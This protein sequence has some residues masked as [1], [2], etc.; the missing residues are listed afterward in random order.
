MCSV[1]NTAASS[2]TLPFIQRPACFAGYCSQ[3]SHR[4]DFGL[5]SSIARDE[6]LS[7]DSLESACPVCFALLCQTSWLKL[8][9]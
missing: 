1:S 4:A 3:A 2:F 6:G 5:P 8:P 7:E 9:G